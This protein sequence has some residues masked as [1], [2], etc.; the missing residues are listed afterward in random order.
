[1][2]YYVML[3]QPSP[4]ALEYP[5]PARFQYDSRNIYLL[6]ANFFKHKMRF[7]YFNGS[8]IRDFHATVCAQI[9]VYIFV[10]VSEEGFRAYM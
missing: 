7:H 6:A 4:L 9:I 5:Q 2:A 8:F 1:M 10:V 3:S